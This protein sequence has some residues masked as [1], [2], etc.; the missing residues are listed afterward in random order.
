MKR[1]FFLTLIIVFQLKLVLI[2]Q[3]TTTYKNI[4]SKLE[5]IRTKIVNKK[6]KS[7]NQ[8]EIGTYNIYDSNK[9]EYE[10]AV[11]KHILYYSDGQIMEETLYN[12]FGTPLE[13]KLYDGL[14][15]LLQEFK[16]VK[17]DTNK[18]SLEELLNDKKS[19]SITTEEK[20]YKFSDRICGWY[21]FKEGKR[22]N[23]K[24]I[25]SWKKYYPSGE[26]NKINEY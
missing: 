11:G 18:E 12:S 3:H 22:L 14:G 13:W 23:G 16:T 26:I 24:K 20:K 15:N 6:Y 19:V 8:K 1:N 21:L 4:V 7:G 5:P 2:A 17:I 9:F 10:I 25:G